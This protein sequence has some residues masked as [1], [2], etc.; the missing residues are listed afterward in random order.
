MN[1][2]THEQFD[3]EIELGELFRIL[4]QNILLIAISAITFAIVG[5]LFTFLLVKPQ[6]QS[7]ATL[8]VN[9]R[10]EENQSITSDE[11][12]TARNLADV[13]TLIIK[14]D[15]VMDQV[16]SNLSLDMT[17][18]ELSKK[19]S[20]SSVNNSQVMKVSTKDTDA[21]LA[22][23]ITSEV[24]NVAPEIIIDTVEAGSVKI[25][26]SAK[27]DDRK[28]SP[29]LKMNVLI[30]FVLGAM[31]SVGYVFVK[32]MLDTTFKSESDIE[33]ILEIPVLGIIPNVESVK[34]GA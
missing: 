16:A 1:N 20:V 34:G 30:S 33:K 22:F 12:N 5:F 17:S 11:I 10:R 18:E 8:I 3:D 13:Y 29:N 14:S 24:V 6:Y 9:N 15:S 32:H 26:S 31:V 19:V 4:K 7:E 28:V 25:I 2:N 27:L 23:K 21:D